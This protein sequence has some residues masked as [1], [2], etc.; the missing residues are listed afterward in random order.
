LVI[1][2]I[3]NKGTL[4]FLFHKLPL[5]FAIKKLAFQNEE[6]EKRA[7]ELIIAWLVSLAVLFNLPS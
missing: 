7:A 1:F 4:Q 5:I 6:K 2:L 3:K